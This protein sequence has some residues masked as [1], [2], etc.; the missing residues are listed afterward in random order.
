MTEHI[1]H[2]VERVDYMLA[3]GTSFPLTTQN[4]DLGMQGPPGARAMLD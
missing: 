1:N 4:S 2:G 3:F